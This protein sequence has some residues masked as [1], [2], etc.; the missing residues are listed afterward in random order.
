MF[1]I[2]RPVVVILGLLLL[3][4][5]PAASPARE[6]AATPGAKETVDAIQ[7]IKQFHI[8]MT[9]TEVQRSLPKAVEQDILS[10]NA[11]ENVF[12]LGVDSP[13]TE[14][15]SGYFIFDTGDAPTRRPERLIELTCSLTLRGRSEPFESI[16]QKVSDA[17]G[18]PIEL[19]NSRAQIHQAGWQIP[20]QSVL[21]L[22]Y[23]VVQNPGGAVVDFVIKGPKK[24]RPGSQPVA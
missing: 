4:T 12:M 11:S 18:E 6:M 15:W 2:E 10:Y 9:Y 19:N 1:R 21:T 16:V 3:A 13:T 24:P 5:A 22:E 17:F 7:F 20:G 23:T 14:N 8:G